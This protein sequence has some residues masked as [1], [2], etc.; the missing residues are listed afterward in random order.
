MQPIL[1]EHLGVMGTYTA[2]HKDEQAVLSVHK[3]LMCNWKGT[4]CTQGKKH[5]SHPIACEWHVSATHNQHSNPASAHNLF[6]GS[7]QVS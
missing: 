2:G 4:Q 5:N 3:E 7:K 1:N 6:G